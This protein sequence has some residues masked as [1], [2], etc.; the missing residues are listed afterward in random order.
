MAKNWTHVQDIIKAATFSHVQ[1]NAII[2]TALSK[3]SI[4]GALH[5]KQSVPIYALFLYTCPAAAQPGLA[6]WRLTVYATPTVQYYA[7]I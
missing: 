2:I 6:W 3:R 5:N 7:L 4:A 1:I